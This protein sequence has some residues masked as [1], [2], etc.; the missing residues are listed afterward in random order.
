MEDGCG[1]DRA[2]GDLSWIVWRAVV[3]V[4][5]CVVCGE[6]LVGCGCVVCK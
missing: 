4:L 3:V 2:Q 1:V 5:V 6:W